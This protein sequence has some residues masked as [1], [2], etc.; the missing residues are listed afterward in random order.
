MP[1]VEEVFTP[2]KPVSSDLFATRRHE[3]LQE[4][5]QDALDE[6]G[7]QV[8]LHGDTGVGKTSLVQYLMAQRKISHIRVECGP[9][10]EDMIRDVLGRVVGEAE[11]ETLAKNSGSSELGVGILSFLA[12]KSSSSSGEEVRLAKY[13]RSLSVLLAEAL[14]LAGIRVLFLDN[15]ENVHAKPHKKTSVQQIVELLKLL[16]D[17]S[18]DRVGEV[19]AVVAGIPTAS[20]ML[21]SLDKATA[22]RTAQIE[23]GRMPEDELDQILLRGGK[24]LGVDFEPLCRYRIIRESDGFPYYT[25]LLALHACRKALRDRRHTVTLEDFESSLDDILADCDLALRRGYIS[26]VETSGEVRV[27]RSIL[28][29]IASVN[30]PEVTF[31]EIRESFLKLH[32]EY[33]TPEQLNF[34]STAMKALKE[35][36]VILED[37][38]RPKSRKN[39]YRFRNPLMRAYVLLQ[40]AKERR[41]AN[42]VHLSL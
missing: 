21:I 26:A 9:P 18:S 3:R 14:E 19:K 17:R 15:F 24:K 7:R 5:V 40:M 4:R 25:H 8:V 33:G 31:K 6:P 35:T 1:K 20:E 32:P 42:Q 37:S 10:F 36:Y 41:N 12:G 38:G 27:R 2:A 30:K 16:S 22:R 23:V 28:E 39:A 11:I 29:A 34:L 13:P